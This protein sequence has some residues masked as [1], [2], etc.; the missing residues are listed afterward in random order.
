MIGMLRE[1]LNVAFQAWSFLLFAWVI[2]SWIPGIDQGHPVVRGIHKVVEPT[3][4][5]FRRLLPSLG[6]M[7]VSPLIA[8]A[9]YQIAWQILDR[10][11]YQMQ[12]GI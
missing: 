7:D 2:M 4:A 1:V 8:I 11:L 10:I 6:P 12:G 3:I 5:P 9:F